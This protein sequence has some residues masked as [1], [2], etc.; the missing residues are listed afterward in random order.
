MK[1]RCCVWMSKRQAGGPSARKV[2]FRRVHARRDGRTPAPAVPLSRVPAAHPKLLPLGRTLARLRHGCICV[3]AGLQ[4]ALRRGVLGSSPMCVASRSPAHTACA[5]STRLYT[6]AHRV[7]ARSL[8]CLCLASG[9]PLELCLS[10]PIC[11]C[12]VSDTGPMF[13][14]VRAPS[15]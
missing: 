10:A 15:W 5:C 6:A 14:K 12:L 3:V 2:H 7:C 9:A 8:P 4:R 13:I 11:L 1:I